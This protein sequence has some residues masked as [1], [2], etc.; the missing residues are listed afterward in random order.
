M[1][2]KR[3]SDGRP[4]KVRGRERERES[5]LKRKRANE[6]ENEI[7]GAGEWVLGWVGGRVTKVEHWFLTKA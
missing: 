5:E 4:E 6:S 2:H 3:E 7:I 1:K